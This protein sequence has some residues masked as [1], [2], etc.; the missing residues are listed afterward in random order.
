MPE[1][2]DHARAPIELEVDYKKLNSF[3]ADYTKNI[4]KGGTFIKT[5]KA[6]PH[7]DALPLPAHRPGPRRA[8]RAE[9]RGDPREPL[10]RDARDGNPLR[11]GDDA[12]AARVRGASSRRSWPRASGRSS[13]SR[14][15]LLP[16]G[17]ARSQ[18]ARRRAGGSR[19]ASSEPRHVLE[20]HAV[21]GRD[22]VLPRPAAVHL[23]DVAARHAHVADL[24]RAR[25]PRSRRSRRS[26]PPRR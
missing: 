6:L 20:A 3:F 23:E 8:V 1:H 5:R 18:R 24:R 22:A 14:E 11:L 16:Q 7:R 10:G 13:A 26:G 9:R 2:R 17:P 19:D 12:G 15:K 21:A 4:S 25:A